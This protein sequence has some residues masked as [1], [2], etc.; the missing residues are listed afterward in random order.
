MKEEQNKDIIELYQDYIGDDANVYRYDYDK[1]RYYNTGISVKGNRGP[2]GPPGRPG[3]PGVSPHIDPITKHWMIGDVD[4]GVVA[5][6]QGGSSFSGSYDDLT[7]KPDLK[8]VATSGSYNDLSDKPTIPAAQ[9]QA[10]WNQTNTS[11][12]DYIKNKPATTVNNILGTTGSTINGNYITVTVNSKLTGMASIDHFL[13]K[14]TISSG[15]DSKKIKIQF[16]GEDTAYTLYDATGTTEITVSGVGN[17]LWHVDVVKTNQK[18]LLQNRVITENDL[19]NFIQTSETQGLL[20]NDGTVDTNSYLTS[21]PNTCVTSS[22]SGLKL[23]VVASLP[24]NPDAN[25]VYIVQ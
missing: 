10:D 17:S 25:T 12:A 1:K 13:I 7:N 16:T 22:T 24:A 9:V 23:E 5:E 11:S 18:C 19:N 4:T 2:A 6:G 21:V 3:T 8:T 14:F 20:K 15:N